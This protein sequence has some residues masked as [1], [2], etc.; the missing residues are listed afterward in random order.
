MQKPNIVPI[1]AN[2]GQDTKQVFSPALFY[3]SFFIRCAP[4]LHALPAFAP[5]V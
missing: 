2:A 3:S 1:Y 4:A 5:I